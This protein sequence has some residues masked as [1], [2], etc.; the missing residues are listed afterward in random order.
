MERKEAG[1]RAKEEKH[2]AAISMVTK[3][4]GKSGL[5]TFN[6]IY[7]YHKRKRIRK[8]MIYL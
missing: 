5:R 3:S 1:K 4:E 2:T 7:A 8:I 6:A